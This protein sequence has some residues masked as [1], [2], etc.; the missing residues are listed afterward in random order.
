MVA[1]LVLAPG[2]IQ[3]LV[4]GASTGAEIKLLSPLG[5]LRAA[6]DGQYKVAAA[7]YWVSFLLVQA[8][9]WALLLGASGRLRRAWRE[10]RGEKIVPAPAPADK[11]AT[12]PNGPWLSC[13]WTPPVPAAADEED[14]KAAPPPSR[15]LAENA[16]PIA[17]L[18]QRQRGLQA[19]LWAAAVFGLAS[20]LVPT[21]LF[22]FW[23]PRS[24]WMFIMPLD[25]AESV[26]EGALFAWAASRFFVEAQRTGELE[27]LLTTPLGATQ[28]VSTQW[29]VLKRRLRWPMLLL[30]APALLGMVSAFAMNAAWLGP[31]PSLFRL[32][33]VAAETLNCARIFFGIGAVC[34]LGIWFGLRAGGQ[35]QAIVLTVAVAR[36]LPALIGILIWTLLPAL[37][38]VS[39]G[40]ASSV[41]A[42]VWQ[43][44][45]QV[46]GLGF[47]VG[48][49]LL[50]RHYLLSGLGAGEL[51]RFDFRRFLVSAARETVLAFRKARHWTPS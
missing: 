15:P 6:E 44:L 43:L 33:Y 12:E 3:F 36:A 2:L 47:Y 18:L 48:L 30:L 8:A 29:Q 32:Q 41:L 1:A 24:Y 14:Q 40:W 11:A 10:E 20:Q 9:G 17:W 16:N 42:I 45:P 7:G 38:R 13:S 27:L 21:I 26:I 22:R 35:A 25:F 34:W 39:F 5:T 23:R 49:I 50:A 37:R 31:S 28:L 4:W 19:I 46:V 51:G